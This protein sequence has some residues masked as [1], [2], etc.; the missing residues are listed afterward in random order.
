MLIVIDNCFSPRDILG[1]GH[2]LAVSDIRESIPFNRMEVSVRTERDQFPKSRSTSRST[3][4][5]RFKVDE[6]GLNGNEES[7]PEKL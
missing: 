2:P 4:Q 1:G 3:R 7:G 6:V 5:Q